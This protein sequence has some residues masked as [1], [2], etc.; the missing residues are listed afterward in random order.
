MR[1]TFQPKT[2]GLRQGAPKGRRFALGWLHSKNSGEVL[3]C[4]DSIEAQC[5]HARQ[6]WLM[7]H[8]GAVLIG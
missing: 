4:H 3:T 7:V 6:V 2:A 1:Q 5:H 8:S